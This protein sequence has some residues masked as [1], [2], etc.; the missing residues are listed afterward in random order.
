MYNKQTKTWR[1]YTHYSRK[2]TRVTTAGPLGIFLTIFDQI[3]KLIANFSKML[4][5]VM[6]WFMQ[7]SKPLWNTK[8][9]QNT[10]S[11]FFSFSWLPFFLSI[12]MG[13]FQFHLKMDFLD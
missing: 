12:Q 2:I 7:I 9:K 5:P 4:T 3:S 13:S 1:V 10:L 8:N 6:F 11:V